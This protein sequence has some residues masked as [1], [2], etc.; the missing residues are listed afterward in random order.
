MPYNFTRDK[1]QEYDF[2]EFQKSKDKFLKIISN[3]FKIGENYHFMAYFENEK[4]SQYTIHDLQ[5]FSDTFDNVI[6]HVLHI[7]GTSVNKIV[8]IF[9]LPQNILGVFLAVY[10]LSRG[11]IFV[12]TDA[13]CM[14]RFS[15]QIRS[16]KKIFRRIIVISEFDNIIEVF[17]NIEFIEV[18][19]THFENINFCN[20]NFHVNFINCEIMSSNV[21]IFYQVYEVYPM[22]YVSYTSGTTGEP[23]SVLVTYSSFMACLSDSIKNF[24]IDGKSVV[25]LSSPFTF[26]PSILQIAWCLAAKCKILVVEKSILLKPKFC[27]DAFL[28]AGLTHIQSTPSLFLNFGINETYRLLNDPLSKIRYMIFGGENFPS[29]HFISGII[30]NEK[31]TNREI[32]FV[33]LYGS[34]EI[35]PWTSFFKISTDFLKKY[36]NNQCE[37]PIIGDCFSD[38]FPAFE[39]FNEEFYLLSIITKYRL[40][41][42]DGNNENIHPQKLKL[43]K[44]LKIPTNDLVSISNDFVNFVSRCNNC[45]K[46]F[47]YLI[48]LEVLNTKIAEKC[49]DIINQSIVVREENIKGLTIVLYYIS[50]NDSDIKDLLSQ[51]L[52]SEFPSYCIPDYFQNVKKFPLN[53]N[54]KIDLKKLSKENENNIEITNISSYIKNLIIKSLSQNSKNSNFDLKMNFL[55][56]GGDSF[57][58]NF[59]CEN[60]KRDLFQNLMTDFDENLFFSTL[61]NKSI[62]DLCENIQIMLKAGENNFRKTSDSFKYKVD[63]FWKHNTQKCI[64]AIPLISYK[65]NQVFAVSH[66]GMIVCIEIET[67]IVIWEKFLTNRIVSTPV[68]I[69]GEKFIVISSYDYGIYCFYR[70]TGEIFWEFKTDDVIKIDLLSIGDC[71]VI[72]C[73]N[74]GFM[75]FLDILNKIKIFKIRLDETRI[76]CPPC[77]VNKNKRIYAATIGGL[78]YCLNN[79]GRIIWKSD[80]CQPVF[81]KIITTDFGIIVLGVK[82]NIFYFDLYSG[83][84]LYR[85]DNLETIY[86]NA[87]YFEEMEKLFITTNNGVIFC[88]DSKNLSFVTKIQLEKESFNFISFF[89]LKDSKIQENST[90][91]NFIVSLSR[92]GNLILLDPSNLEIISQYSFGHS[93]STQPVFYKNYMIFGTAINTLFCYRLD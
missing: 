24:E 83:K 25:L 81:S 66:S 4:F 70:K 45:I 34:T 12:P 49:S 85:F 59:I 15:T 51:R 71:G 78:V 58:A 8:F 87:L 52:R 80:I 31:L 17:R 26:D 7:F 6:S 64:D 89:E 57:M 47:G 37:I 2:K 19:K 36:I 50:R 76:S 91:K 73:S 13:Y 54:G 56:I 61:Q 77:Y 14:N 27:V 42:I 62:Q 46:R 86:G 11:I 5:S 79:N 22:M 60:I 21:P 84:I 20:L 10:F 82:G 93:C 35:S 63:L 40:C 29:K 72:A 65:D 67:G 39:K 74:E 33:N 48:N 53:S 1:M 32:N 68:F 38:T 28:Q 18:N 16:L 75:Y 44:E 23:K 3:A 43:E 9:C 88:L 69:A 92:K 41:V 55:D 90:F 30:P